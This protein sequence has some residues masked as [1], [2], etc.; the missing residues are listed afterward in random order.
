MRLV[1]FVAVLA[2]GADALLYNG[3]YTHAAWREASG[4]VE[5]LLDKAPPAAGGIGRNG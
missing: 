4:H 2:L 5:R 1:L 3:A